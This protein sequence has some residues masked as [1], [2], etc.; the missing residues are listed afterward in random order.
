M[1]KITLKIWSYD[2]YQQI[3][4]Y[5]DIYLLYWYRIK[6]KVFILRKS[7]VLNKKY[8]VIIEIPAVYYFFYRPD[9]YDG[10]MYKN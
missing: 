10:E 5:L 2:K 7:A 1:I 9:N 4:E 3:E 8:I 6:E